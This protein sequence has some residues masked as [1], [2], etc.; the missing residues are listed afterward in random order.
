MKSLSCYKKVKNENI[1]LIKVKG[2]IKQLYSLYKKLLRHD[3]DIN[4]VYDFIAIRI[5]VKDIQTCYAALG[6]IHK[7]MKPLKGRIKDYIAQP[8]PNG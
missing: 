4:R 5:I 6:I 7:K 1:K 2:R 3:K 8:N